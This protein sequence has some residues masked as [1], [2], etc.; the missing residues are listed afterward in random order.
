[1]GTKDLSS[2]AAPRK[3]LLIGDIT[4]AFL[5][6]DAISKLSCEVRSNMPDAIDAAVKNS[7]AAI[8][9]VMSGM[10][11]KLSSSLRK[12]RQ[13]NC[14]A[15]IVLLAQ[16]YEEPLAMQ[17]IGLVSNGTGVVDDYLICPIEANM[18]YE[19]IMP[20]QSRSWAETD[21]S[22]A[23]D[24]NIEMKIRMLEKLATEDDLTGLK[25]RRYICSY[26]ILLK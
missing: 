19:Y 21:A 24:T 2:D 17:L 16:M 8:A 14:D 6:V 25:S 9:V 15:K 23:V 1:M 13:E 20:S 12:L 4:R 11:G 22:V 18:F 26:R 7:F 5:D 10:S 3:I